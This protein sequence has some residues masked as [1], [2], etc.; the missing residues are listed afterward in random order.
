M[1]DGSLPPTSA[2]TRRAV[3]ICNLG[4]ADRAENARAFLFN[5]FSDRNILPLPGWLRIPLA[6]LISTIRAPHTRKLYERLGGRS[7]LFEQTEAQARAIE[8]AAAA[9]GSD[10]KVFIAMRYWHPFAKEAIAQV[11]DYGADEVVVVPLYPQFSATTTTTILDQLRTEA[12]LQGLGASISSVCCYPELDGLIAATARLVKAEIG[13]VGSGGQRVRLLLSAH[14]LPKSLIARGDPYQWQVERTAAAIAKAVGEPALDW[15]VC[16][17]SRLGPVMWLGPSIQQEL[18]SAAADKVAVVVA[19]IAFVSEHLETVV[20]LD[21][22]MREYAKE[23]GVPAYGRVPAVGIS[24]EFI[25]GI[26]RLADRAACAGHL[27]SD[28]GARVCPEKFGLCPHRR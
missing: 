2:R 23:K 17:Q 28:G 11:K 20:E 26:V 21:D 7:I 27:S 3:I 9:R 22:E 5:L 25:D 14:G 18:E 8:A 1:P 6:A 16:Y 24:P 13:K 19:P 4:G 12:R 10:V 15:R